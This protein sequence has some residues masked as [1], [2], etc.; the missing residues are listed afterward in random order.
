MLFN[1]GQ[2][3]RLVIS[4]LLALVMIQESSSQSRQRSYNREGHKDPAPTKGH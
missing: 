3:E 2:R 4:L 1:G